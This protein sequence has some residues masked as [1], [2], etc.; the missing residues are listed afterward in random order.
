[1][2]ND[3]FG[4]KMC[5]R[6]VGFFKNEKKMKTSFLK[7]VYLRINDSFLRVLKKIY[8]LFVVNEYFW[9]KMCF[10]GVGFFKNEKKMEVFF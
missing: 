2:R 10:G 6:G 9:K 8:T 1:M 5:F 7:N 4:K 3:I